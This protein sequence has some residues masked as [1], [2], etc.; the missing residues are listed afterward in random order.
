MATL[1]GQKISNSYKDLLQVSNDNSGIDTTKRSVSDGE[2]TNSPLQLSDSIVNI[3]GT[4]QLKDYYVMG[5]ILIVI[6]FWIS[7]LTKYLTSAKNP[8]LLIRRLYQ[9]NHLR[10]NKIDF[11]D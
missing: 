1:T 8:G 6:I 11:K 5:S 7:T 2:G 10:S 4:F 9:I 3:D